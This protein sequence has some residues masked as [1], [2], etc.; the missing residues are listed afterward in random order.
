MLAKSHLFNPILL[1]MKDSQYTPSTNRDEWLD[2]DPILSTEYDYE[3][4]TT[5]R[6][7][8]AWLSNPGIGRTV[9]F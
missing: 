9:Y 5:G 2:V 7:Q 3:G 8:Y 4:L 1:T 6:H